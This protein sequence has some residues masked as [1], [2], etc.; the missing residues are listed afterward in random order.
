MGGRALDEPVMSGI[1]MRYDYHLG[2]LG[3]LV[4]TGW[5]DDG[6][7]HVIFHNGSGVVP[8]YSEPLLW[9]WGLSDW[10]RRYVESDRS[11]MSRVQETLA[12]V[13]QPSAIGPTVTGTLTRT[14]EALRMVARG[15][16]LEWYDSYIS[17]QS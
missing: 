12:E 2:R 10:R 9:R 7:E 6:V 15:V 4:S 13:R 5:L 11:L 1:A 8:E 16:P 3:G 17:T 14:P